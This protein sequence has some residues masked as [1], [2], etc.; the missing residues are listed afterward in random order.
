MWKLHAQIS[1]SNG[2]EK[3]N[4]DERSKEVTI[5]KVVSHLC[6]TLISK[7]LKISVEHD[8]VVTTLNK[9]KTLNIILSVPS[10]GLLPSPFP[11][12][13]SCL[14]DFKSQILKNRGLSF[15]S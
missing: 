7:E 12:P 9:I 8:R 11:L 2:M 4:N 6:L 1:V 15:E 13:S 10:Y 14:G 3:I 5:R